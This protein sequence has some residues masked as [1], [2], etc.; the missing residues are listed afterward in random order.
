MVL[1]EM[2]SQ[3]IGENYIIIKFTVPVIQS[4]SKV[5][6]RSTNNKKCTQTYFGIP[7]G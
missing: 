3:R 5:R 7:Q 4:V 1:K 2:T 6:C